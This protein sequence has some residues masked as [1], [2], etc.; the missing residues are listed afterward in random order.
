MAED[1]VWLLRRD[2]HLLAAI[3]LLAQA[4]LDIRTE[5]D[6]YLVRVMRVAVGFA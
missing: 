6:Q 1:G 5:A 3:A 2:D 4:Y